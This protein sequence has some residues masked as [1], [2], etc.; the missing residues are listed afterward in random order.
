[1]SVVF[2]HGQEATTRACDP[3]SLPL[4]RQIVAAPGQKK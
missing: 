2:V 1:M 4:E 3:T